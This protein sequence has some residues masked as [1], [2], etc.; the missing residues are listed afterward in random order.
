MQTHGGAAATAAIESPEREFQVRLLVD[1]NMNGAYSHPLSDMTRFVE[2]ASTDRS[3]SGSQSEDLMII[4]G[5]SAAQLTVSL[6]GKYGDLSLTSVFS[7]YQVRSPFWG[8]ETIGMEVTFEIGVK[9][10]VGTVWYPQFVG[11]VRTITPDRGTNAVELTAL[12]RVELLRRPVEFP[13]WS[14]FGPQRVVE[15]KILA[16][17]ADPQWVIDHCLKSSDVSPTPWRPFTR[18]EF[19]LN[20]DDR[21]GPQL[22]VSGVGGIMPTIGW[23]DNWNQQKFP[24]TEAG[25]LPMYEQ[26]GEPHPDAAGPNPKNFYAQGA[27][28]NSTLTYWAADRTR[29]NPIGIQVAGATLIT[30][31]SNATFYQSAADHQV[32]KINVGNGVFIYLVIG[33]SGKF[34]TVWQNG[35]TLIDSPKLTIPTGGSSQRLIATWDAYR[36]GGARVWL[37]AGSVTSGADWTNTGVTPP[38]LGAKDLLQGQIVIDHRT[39]LNDVVYTSTNFGS[40]SVASAKQWAGKEAAY[41]AELDAGLNRLAF[42][43][44]RKAEDAWKVISEVVSAEFGSAFWSED[45]IFKFWNQDTLQDLKS[46]VAKSVTLDEVSGLRITNHLDSI[47]NIWSLVSTTRTSWDKVAFDARNVDEFYVPGVSRRVFTVSI[48]DMLSPNP[49]FAPRYS[50]TGTFPAWT[51]DV[52]FGYVVQWFNGSVWAEDNSKSSG[53]DINAFFNHR[54][55]MQIEIWNGYSEPARLANNNGSAAYRVNSTLIVDDEPTSVLFK[56]L[57]SIGKY[58]GRNIAL[59]GDWHQEFTNQVGLVS[60]MLSKTSTPNPV[61]DAITMA[62]DPRIQ[63]G[64]TIRINDIDGFGERFDVQVYGITRTWSLQ[65]GLSDTYSVELVRPAGSFWDDPVYAI[66]DD[67]F[68]WGV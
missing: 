61:T 47:R 36:P 27:A 46:V 62:G 14:M 52:V 44:I 59:S 26:E 37:Q 11:Y 67:T 15:G 48:D 24:A 57:T 20:D 58:G 4:E 43:P 1:W 6:A 17:Q 12:D 30:R 18:E 66:W 39:A 41:A 3:L 50:T 28:G 51:N 31:G 54:G 25:G 63:L 60:Q 22:W 7:P 32:V 19:G 34:W 45:G 56:D 64:D 68:M 42:L 35:A 9:T 38:G 53:I 65:E 5:V 16:Q 49:G 40:L 33:D 55:E 2:S 10:S 23:L 8:H 29:I 21:T 13:A